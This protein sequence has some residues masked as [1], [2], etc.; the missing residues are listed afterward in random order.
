MR[1]HLIA[2]DA[3]TIE[4]AMKQIVDLGKEKP[5]NYNQFT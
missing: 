4:K 5:I 3:T 1:I 2:E